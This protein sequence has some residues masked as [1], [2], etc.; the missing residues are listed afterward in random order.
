MLA[1]LVCVKLSSQGVARIRCSYLDHHH[2][3][4]AHSEPKGFLGRSRN[5]LL[6]PYS[7][8]VWQS[9]VWDLP[10][11]MGISSQNPYPIPLSPPSWQL[12]HSSCTL[13]M[14]KGP[15]GE[16][17]R[18]KPTEEAGGASLSQYAGWR[19]R[20][21]LAGTSEAITPRGL[22]KSPHYQSICRGPLTSPPPPATF[23]GH[24]FWVCAPREPGVCFP[25][26]FPGLLSSP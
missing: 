8:R 17:R 20:G 19:R 6:L 22:L 14:A 1:E 5:S 2:V 12:S 21:L 16:S 9:W 3:I 18:G 26:A 15:G 4:S 24:L 10:G 23:W 7:T 13:Q 11:C 25:P